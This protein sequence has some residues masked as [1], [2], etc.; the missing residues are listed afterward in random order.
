V[1]A[2]AHLP[3]AGPRHEA[4]QANRDC[5]TPGIAE[6]NPYRLY[7]VTNPAVLASLNF[8]PFG[9]GIQPVDFRADHFEFREDEYHVSQLLT[10]FRLAH[11]RSSPD[12][13]RVMPRWMIVDLLLMP[14]AVLLAVAGQEHVV[15]VARDFERGDDARIHGRGREYAAAL[16]DL[17]QMAQA[18]GYSGPLPVAGYAAI[19]TPVPGRW[20]GGSLWWSLVPGAKLGYSVRRIALRCYGAEHEVGVTQFDNMRALHA[21]KEFGRLRITHTNL[22]AHPL[23]NT[24]V[25]EVDLRELPADGSPAHAEQ[26]VRELDP[27]AY[28]LPKDAAGAATRLGRIQR[29]IEQGANYY[30]IPDSPDRDKS[31]PII[32]TDG[33]QHERPEPSSCDSSSAPNKA[34]SHLAAGIRAGHPYKPYIISNESMFAKLN[35]APFGISLHPIDFCADK[36]RTSDGEDCAVP[37]LLSLLSRAITLSYA[38]SGLGMPSWAMVELAMMSSAVLLILADQDHLAD[39]ASRLARE[40]VTRHRRTRL[41]PLPEDDR[42]RLRNANSLRVLLQAAKRIN[43][44]GPLPIAGYA[45]TATPSPGR[46]VGWSLWSLVPGEKLGYTVKRLALACYGVTAQT[47]VMQFRMSRGVDVLT[48]FGTPRVT[49]VDVPSHPAPHAFI[50]EL[51]ISDLPPDAAPVEVSQAR[52]ATDEIDPY[53]ADLRGHLARITRDIERGAAY[54]LLPRSAGR[55]YSPSIPLERRTRLLRTIWFGSKLVVRTLR[56]RRSENTA[57]N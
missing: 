42:D 24:F 11:A 31:R 35:L 40:P 1:K 12:L 10:L 54:Y 37:G 34:D 30:V 47:A 36:F 22:A 46:W 29:D 5:F 3:D 38:E 49:S 57:Q 28:R 45:A 19:P 6:G 13:Q 9:I 15:S 27:H 16:R 43:Y 52:K 51:D 14:S 32:Y 53:G 2:R 55:T 25:Y 20:V 33:G 23:Q 17:L 48:E 7:L 41:I 26:D 56:E 50:Y 21:Q 8:S 44:T 39:V 4:T 18:R